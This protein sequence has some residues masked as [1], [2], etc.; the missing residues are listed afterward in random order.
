MLAE[1]RPAF[2]MGMGVAL[3]S[4]VVRVETTAINVAHFGIADNDGARPGGEPFDLGGPA[5]RRATWDAARVT[6]AIIEAGVPARISH[7]AGTHCCNLA[8]HTCLGALERLGL[9]SPC[10]FLHLPYLPEQVVWL[11]R[12]RAGQ[13]ATAPGSSL[14]PPS[15]SFDLQIMAARAAIRVLAEPAAALAVQVPE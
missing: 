13:A 10:G 9:P 14:D 15:M 12:N 8:L 7:H 4:P 2:V 3:G 11:M 1:H 5:A 6:A